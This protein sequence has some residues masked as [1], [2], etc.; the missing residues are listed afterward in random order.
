[1]RNVEFIKRIVLGGLAGGVLGTAVYW[2]VGHQSS[3]KWIVLSA[4]I[5]VVVGLLWPV[6][7]SVVIRL[8]VED[9]RLEQVE[10]QGLKFTS[11]GM[12]RRVAWNR[13][14]RLLLGLLGIVRSDYYKDSRSALAGRQ[15]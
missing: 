15:R 10:V 3:V 14:F 6:G 1:M 4:V 8:R 5:G 11:S 2:I 9:G 12:Q 13:S 7:R